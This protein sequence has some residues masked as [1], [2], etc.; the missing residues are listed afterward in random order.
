MITK[1]HHIEK[2]NTFYPDELQNIYGTTAFEILESRY[3]NAVGDAGNSSVIRGSRT[4]SITV[5]R[6]T[7]TTAGNTNVQQLASAWPTPRSNKFIFDL[8]RHDKVTKGDSL[9]IPAQIEY[10][11]VSGMTGLGDEKPEYSTDLAPVLTPIRKAAVWCKVSDESLDDYEGLASWMNSELTRQLFC[12]IDNQLLNGTGTAPSL[13]GLLAATGLQTQSKS[14]DTLAVAITKAIAKVANA[15]FYPT[16]IVVSPDDFASLIAADPITF[17]G[18]FAGIE[19]V[20]SSFVTNSLPVVGDFT[21]ATVFERSAMQFEMT[22]TNEDDFIN[23]LTS[24]RAEQRLAL[25]VF[26]PRA[27]CKVIA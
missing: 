26:A 4:G 18:R 11:S 19:L 20:A 27:F 2:K 1:P 8:F 6:A 7:L 13:N 14:S 23:N 17:N 10:G 21:A 9:I 5:T 3:R 25:A 22:N 12:E 15:G 16:A 24:I